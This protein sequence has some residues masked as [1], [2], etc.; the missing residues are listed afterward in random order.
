MADDSRGGSSI[1]TQV[2]AILGAFAVFGLPLIAVGAFNF[3]RYF[4]ARPYSLNRATSWRA[5]GLIAPFDLTVH[6]LNV[7]FQPIAFL[8]AV[9]LALALFPVVP[10]KVM[11]ELLDRHAKHRG[12]FIFSLSI[13]LLVVT[14]SAEWVMWS[15]WAET[16]P[17]LKGLRGNGL[18][19]YWIL[20]NISVISFVYATFTS[21]FLYSKPNL[22]V[23]QPMERKVG[24]R[25][26][27][28]GD[29]RTDRAVPEGYSSKGS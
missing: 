8:S 27:A 6:G 11:F 20:V 14:G 29:T 4:E 25:A 12:W 24:L 13:V 1:V 17:Q 26:V 2:V 28:G 9:S 22:G 16:N 3:E 21:T 15:I 18:A 10:I 7:V 23:R 19:A 5:V